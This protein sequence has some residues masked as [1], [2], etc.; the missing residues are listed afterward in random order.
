[1]VAAD[2]Q[3]CWPFINEFIDSNPIIIF[4]GIIYFLF[5]PRKEMEILAIHLP[6]FR[7][8]ICYLTAEKAKL[9]SA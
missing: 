2:S 5:I 3:Y 9:F 1:M 6:T 7:Q 8:N 4:S